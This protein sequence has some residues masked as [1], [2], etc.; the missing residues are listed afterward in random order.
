MFI[1]IHTCKNN[2]SIS[3][4]HRL[5]SSIGAEDYYSPEQIST[6]QR[7]ISENDAALSY[8]SKRRFQSNSHEFTE[9]DVLELAKQAY[10]KNPVF[11]IKSEKCALLVIDMQDEFVKPHGTP[12]WVP[13]STRQMPR[14]KRLLEFCRNK[15]ISVIFTVFART[16]TIILIAH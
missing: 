3:I 12:F 8:M 1:E 6:P 14:I 16:H 15:G 9:R 7:Q 11:E 13:E 10:E 5:Q 2:I 4:L